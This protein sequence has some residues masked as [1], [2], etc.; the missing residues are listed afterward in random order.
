MRVVAA[1]VCLL[2]S[3]VNSYSPAGASFLRAPHQIHRRC[4][5]PVAAAKKKAA[6]K[7]KAPAS[8]GGFGKPSGGGG[9]GKAGSAGVA[10]PTPAE[11]LKK[12]MDVYTQLLNDRPEASEDDEGSVDSTGGADDS[13]VKYAICLRSTDSSAPPEFSDWVPVAL[14]NLVC[15]DGALPSELAPQAVGSLCREVYEAGAQSI[16]ALRKAPV[17]SIEYA[18]ETIS[19]FETH[20]CDGLL[21]RSERR[22]EAAKTLSLEVSASA[23]EVKKAH[24]KLMLELHPDRFVGDDEGAAAAQAKMLE[25]QNAYEQLGG[26]MGGAHG[27]W[28]ASIGGKARVDFSGPLTK[29]QLGPLGK[30][31]VGQEMDVTLGGWRAGVYPMQPDITREFVTRNTMR[32]VKTEA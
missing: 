2:L 14:I 12:S 26:G 20:V 10:E 21:G 4:V 1:L 24:R 17:Q 8:G 11:R 30:A 23:G 28:Y 27:S 29:E 32:S 18:F 25:V 19:S 31:R 6:K 22:E 3:A 9:F 7:G 15:G 5:A 13:L 16:P